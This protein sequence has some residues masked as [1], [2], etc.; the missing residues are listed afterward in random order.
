MGSPEVAIDAIR[1]RLDLEVWASAAE[2]LPGEAVTIGYQSRGADWITIHGVPTSLPEGAMTF[3]PILQDTYFL[4][5]AQDLASEQ[6]VDRWVLVRVAGS[7]APN[8][9]D[10]QGPIILT[11]AARP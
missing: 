2:V 9:E 11:A 4:V 3:G 5:T 8:P 1:D 7:P 10:G 6:R